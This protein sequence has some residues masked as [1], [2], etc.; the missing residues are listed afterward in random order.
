MYEVRVVILEC[1]MPPQCPLHIGED[2]E[3]TLELLFAQNFTIFGDQ[4][5]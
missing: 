3:N 2:H 4:G 1:D 5:R